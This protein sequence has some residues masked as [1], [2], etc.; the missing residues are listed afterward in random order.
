MV[1]HDDSKPALLR[2]IRAATAAGASAVDVV[3]RQLQ[4]FA[5]MAV[6]LRASRNAGV[7]GLEDLAL[8]AMPMGTDG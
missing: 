3:G 7:V 5:V 1:G 6:D 2:S 8:L 4:R